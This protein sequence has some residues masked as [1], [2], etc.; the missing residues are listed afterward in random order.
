MITLYD[1]IPGASTAA[2]KILIGYP[3]DTIKTKVQT[4][5]DTNYTKEFKNIIRHD[6]FFSLYRGFVMPLSM[7]MIKRGFQLA[8]FENLNK[9]HSSLFAGTFA[10]LLSSIIS[11]PINTVKISMQST[12]KSY[13]K[14]TAD[15]M[16]KIYK[17][18]GLSGF[19]KGFK[20]NIIRDSLF[21]GLYLGTY[22]FLRDV[23]PKNSYYYSI[24]GI[25]SSVVTW[26]ILIPFDTY[27][28]ILQSPYNNN[29]L[30]SKIKHSPLLLWRGLVPMLIRT[31]PVTSVNMIV[32]EK[33]RT[34]I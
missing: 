10:G 9:N 1:L 4:N 21:S 2:G 5:F 15:C 26:S 22:G 14:N 12:N 19:G 33:V 11:N 30:L 17:K 31:I 7:T 29:N 6:G 27:R 24:A 25:L 28:S 13:Y 32:Y 16:Y 8:I 20:I 18:E 23:F 34:S 3:F